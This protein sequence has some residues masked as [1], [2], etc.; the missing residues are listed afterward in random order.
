MKKLLIYF[1][2]FL[3][4]LGSVAAQTTDEVR[5]VGFFEKF[6][7]LIN[8][9]V[10][11]IAFS[12]NNP[13]PNEIITYTGSGTIPSSV[14]E[15]I[16][17]SCG[18]INP[19]VVPSVYENCVGPI[20]VKNAVFNLH[21]ELGDT[22]SPE[23]NPIQ[24]FDKTNTLRTFLAKKQTELAQQSSSVCGKTYKIEITTSAPSVSDNYWMSFDWKATGLVNQRNIEIFVASLGK[25][26]T[27][28]QISQPILPPDAVDTDGD[29]LEDSIDDCDTQK[30]NFNNFQDTD[31]CPDTPPSPPPPSIICGNTICESGES[32]TTCV[33]DCPIV[34]QPT[35]NDKDGDGALDSEDKC[36]TITPL[37]SKGNKVNVPSRQSDK[38]NELYGCP[39]VQIVQNQVRVLGEP[40]YAVGDRVPVIFSLIKDDNFDLTGLKVEAGIYETDVPFLANFAVVSPGEVLGSRNLAEIPTCRNE[41]HVQAAD[42]LEIGA[43]AF[44]TGDNK[45]QAT[46]IL[47][48]KMPGQVALAEE[49]FAIQVTTYKECGEAFSSESRARVTRTITGQEKHNILIEPTCVTVSGEGTDE[50]LTS[51]STGSG[52]PTNTRSPLTIDEL[53]TATPVQLSLSSCNLNEEC[54]PREGFDV[55]CKS[56]E[57]LKVELASSGVLRLAEFFAGP[58]GNKGVCIAE[59]TDKASFCS[60]T[61]KL[62]FADT[63]FAGDRCTSGSILLFGAILMLFVIFVIL[64]GKR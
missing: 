64:G 52:T 33:Q 55:S 2:L 56:A 41:D 47:L 24:T 15:N 60:F 27:V 14:C 12:D 18:I 43:F 28:G 46:Y 3:L 30:E 7:L 31:G 23:P 21:K 45:N 50:C 44:G 49:K 59:A 4:V 53:D 62:P 8:S 25:K 19:Q 38:S 6:L 20:I 16:Q 39:I 32:S 26:F 9:D 11:S 10:F 40:R 42:L 48:P 17:F 35:I 5:E 1:F 22:G 63:Q 36:P 57:K 29:G 58:L 13:D 54:K 51:S 37:D 34:P 61:E